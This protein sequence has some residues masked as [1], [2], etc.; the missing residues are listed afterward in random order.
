[1]LFS[2]VLQLH[3]KKSVALAKEGEQ[4]FSHDITFPLSK[5]SVPKAWEFTD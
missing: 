3:D 5:V 1:M 2:Q 4:S